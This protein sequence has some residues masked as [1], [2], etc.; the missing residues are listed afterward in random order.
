MAEGGGGRFDGCS[1]GLLLQVRCCGVQAGVKFK[2]SSCSLF[3]G[4]LAC[5]NHRGAVVVVVGIVIY[6]VSKVMQLKM[7]ILV[8]IT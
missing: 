7:F 6:I 4:S 1:N 2:M 3:L 5:H 8:V